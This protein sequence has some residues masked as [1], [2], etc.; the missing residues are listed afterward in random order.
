MN[1]IIF[2]IDVNSAYL[3]WTA[4]ELLRKEPDGV[5]IRT[6][7]AIIGGDRAT[8][9]GIVLA[10]SLPAKKLYQIETAEPVA[11]ALRKCPNLMVVPPDRE[12]YAKRSRELMEYLRTLTPDIEQVSIDECY[13]DFTGIAH[14]YPSYMDAARQIRETIRTQMGFTVNVG[15]SS[16]KVLAKMASD[17][18]K[19]DK[20]HTLFP[21]EL[22]SKLWHLPVGRLY[23]AGHSSAETL[24]KLGILTIGDLARTDPDLLSLHLKSHGRLLWEY[25]NG[26]DD[27]PVVSAPSQLKGIGNSTTL[28]SDVTSPMEAKQIL[29]RLCDKVAMRLRRDNSLAASVCV[30]IKYNTFACVSH[31]MQLSSPTQT[32]GTL[33][34]HV[35]SLFDA[36]WDGTPIRLLGVRTGKLV[37]P[38]APVQLTIFDYTPEDTQLKKKQE[39]LD[40]ALD[41]IRSK[42]GRDAVL[43]GRTKH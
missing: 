32:G 1:T 37:K 33:Y 39:K 4:A 8:R 41:K 5:D 21:H 3:S 18:E 20:T 16:K 11:S 43:R 40:A 27:T 38:D 35:C 7:P 14:R 36:L 10:K 6:I 17:F 34:A 31:Q 24:N 29:R 30:E 19:P 13:L 28:A 12:L 22:P 2:H 25:A 15:I 23:M 42:Y 26:I 9:H